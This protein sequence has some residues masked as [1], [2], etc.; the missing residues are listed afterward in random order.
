MTPNYSSVASEAIARAKALIAAKAAEKAAREAARLAELPAVHTAEALAVHAPTSSTITLSLNAE[1]QQAVDYGFYGK[2]FCLIGAAGTGKTTTLK[3]VLQ[4]MI[5]QHRIPILGS[6]TSNLQSG[7][8]GVALIAYTRRAVR[9]IARQMPAELKKHCLTFH[10]LVEYAPEYYTETNE[11]G[12]EVNRMRFA[13]TYN[14]TCKLPSNLRFIVVDEA[15]MLSMDHF[16]QLIDALEDPSQVQFVFLGDLN[17]LPP[18]YGIPILG[19]KL[20]DLPV[21]ELTRVYRQA[22]ESPI[23]SLALA[24]KD[25][26]FDTLVSDVRA[27]VFDIE[28]C[29]RRVFDPRRLPAG[30]VVLSKPGRGKVTLHS[31]KKKLDKDDGLLA[32]QGHLRMMVRDGAYVPDEDLVLCPWNTSF[33]T[34]ELNKAIADFLGKQ[35]EAEIHEVIAGFEKH[36]FAV[37]DK[38]MVEKQEAVILSIKRNPRYMGK[39]PRPAS[40]KVNRWGVAESDDAVDMFSE[41]LTD[42]DIDLLLAHAANIE[43]RTTEASHVIR[44]RFFDSDLEQD[45][46]AAGVINASQFAYA[47][48]VHKAQGSECRRVILITSHAHAAMCSRE[49]IYT[50]ITRAAEELYLVLENTMLGKAASKPRIKGDTLQDKIAFFE[51]RIS[52]KEAQ[53]ETRDDAET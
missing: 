51:Q 53:M 6:S 10:R 5:E 37:G 45:L 24:I 42:E 3:A 16:Q 26:N 30:K 17:Q 22:L 14:K 12:E 49:L 46:T 25:N 35:R 34:D 33:G 18:V 44:V 2:S 36:Y 20:L 39:R 43:E 13:P 1:Q 47:M 7:T 48:T 40:K 23:I 29:D 31:W 28:G 8:P 4:T 27:G 21:I 52:E 15:S 50:G 11:D 32:M 38:L 9:N 19:K 41:D